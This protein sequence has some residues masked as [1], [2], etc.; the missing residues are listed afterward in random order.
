MNDKIN[1]LL[2]EK[3][4]KHFWNQIKR[5]NEFAEIPKEFRGVII[6]YS[7]YNHY[8]SLGKFYSI[9]TDNNKYIVM[10]LD[11]DNEHSVTI[12][13]SSGKDSSISNVESDL[14]IVYFGIGLKELLNYYSQNQGKSERITKSEI[15]RLVKKIL[16]Y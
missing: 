2:K 12:V 11:N 14:K 9:T 3:L 10:S 1:S 5:I 15:N 8:S 4:G 7:V 16:K 13:D 6:N